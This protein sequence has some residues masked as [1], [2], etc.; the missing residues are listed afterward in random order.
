MHISSLKTNRRGSCIWAKNLNW[1]DDRPQSTSLELGMQ[2]LRQELR[3]RQELTLQPQQILRSEL[4]QMPL[5]ELEL[6]VNAELEQNPFLEEVDPSEDGADS[7]AEE[8]EH[9][10]ETDLSETDDEELEPAA[11]KEETAEV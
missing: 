9:D 8:T 3:L 6:R 2:G 4:I 11:L 1:T 5:L 7:T 10:K